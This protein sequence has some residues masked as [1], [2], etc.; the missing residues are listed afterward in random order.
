MIHRD[1][2]IR[3][4]LL[5]NYNADNIRATSVKVSDFRLTVASENYTH[6]TVHGGELSI[7]YLPPES[8]LK[9]RFSEKSDVWAFG[10]TAWEVFS[11]GTVPFYELADDAVPP[12]VC[13]GGRLFRPASCPDVVWTVIQTCWAT[14]PED[15]PPFSQ[16]AVALGTLPDLDTHA[17]VL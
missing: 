11:N 13:Q 9:R 16:L 15:R 6:R 5:F 3:N 17:N 14:L 2:S 4:V 8:L 12:H 7:R 10:V 1:L